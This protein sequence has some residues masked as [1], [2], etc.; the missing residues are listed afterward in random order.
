MSA[1]REILSVLRIIDKPY[2]RIRVKKI[3]RGFFISSKFSIPVEP[4]MKSL[5]LKINF[6]SPFYIKNFI[7][8]YFSDRKFYQPFLYQVD[9]HSISLTKSYRKGR[10]I[11]VEFLT[12]I[13]IEYWFCLRFFI[14]IIII[15]YDLKPIIVCL[16]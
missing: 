13:P 10:N 11:L 7:V 4:S 8:V 6:Y 14:I 2:D 9:I 15:C 16:Q 3:T 12:N 1:Y 5:H